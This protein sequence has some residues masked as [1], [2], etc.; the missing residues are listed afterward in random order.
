[1]P[2]REGRGGVAEVFGKGGIGDRF[3]QGDTDFG[4]GGALTGLEGR[5]RVG[6]VVREKVGVGVGVGEEVGEEVEGRVFVGGKNEDF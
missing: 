1:M 2:G 3:V 5:E 6:F 4:R